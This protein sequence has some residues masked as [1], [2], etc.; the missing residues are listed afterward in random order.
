MEQDIR[1]YLTEIGRRGGR[2]SRRTLD[3]VAFSSH[4]VRQQLILSANL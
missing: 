4:L 2:K 1:A 3:S